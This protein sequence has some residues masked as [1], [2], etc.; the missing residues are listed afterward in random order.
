MHVEA[1]LQSFDPA[2]P[3]EANRRVVAPL[4]D[5]H[6]APTRT[7]ADHLAREG[8]DPRRI[9][10]TGCTVDELAARAVPARY[11]VRPENY[12][13]A[14]VHRPENTGDL[15]GFARSGR[16]PAPRSRR[17]PGTASCWSPTP[18]ASGRGARYSNGPR[19]WSR[20]STGRPEAV[21]AGGGRPARAGAELAAVLRELLAEVPSPY[22]DGQGP[23]R[24]PPPDRPAPGPNSLP[25]YASCSPRC[26]PRTATGRRPGRAPP[27]SG[28]AT[29]SAPRP[30]YRV[31]RP[32][33]R[34][35]RPP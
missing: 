6:C 3:E 33:Y 24:A 35:A 26:P 27:P 8:I 4:A 29:R 18:A 32:P 25:R 16:P 22:G 9:L 34:A 7:A 15:G 1:G 13:L 5:L 23:G 14:I 20:D 28:P 17:R 30:P 21:R 11:G 2:M 12:L 19:R 10:I 31:P